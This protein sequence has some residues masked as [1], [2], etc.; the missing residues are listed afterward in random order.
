MSVMC[1]RVKYPQT[2]N[3]LLMFKD[4]I[5]PACHVTEAPMSQNAR[6]IKHSITVLTEIYTKRALR[7]NSDSG[8]KRLHSV[9]AINHQ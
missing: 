9:N 5:L 7:Q 6:H 3:T 8:F 1:I 4:H 2:L